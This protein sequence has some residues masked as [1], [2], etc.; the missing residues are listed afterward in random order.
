MSATAGDCV[1]CGCTCT[2]CRCDSDNEEDFFKYGEAFVPMYC[3]PT[4]PT[5]TAE[6]VCFAL[7][8]AE[9]PPPKLLYYYSRTLEEPMTTP[10]LESLHAEIATLKAFALRHKDDPAYAAA[11]SGTGG[12]ALLGHVGRLD[13]EATALRAAMT[14]FDKCLT[15]LLTRASAKP[16]EDRYADA[17]SVLGQCANTIKPYLAFDAGAFTLR[18]LEAA[19][20]VCTAVYASLEARINHAPQAVLDRIVTQIEVGLVVWKSLRSQLP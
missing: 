18:R 15:D 2:P 10:Q 14:A 17:I 11:T 5:G 1:V 20:A 3:V 19:E 8:A 13:Q 12:A 16:V 4:P 7:A 9:Q 6:A